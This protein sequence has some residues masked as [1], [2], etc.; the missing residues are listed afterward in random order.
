MKTPKSGA[1]KKTPPKKDSTN[2]STPKATEAK[3]NVKSTAKKATPKSTPKEIAAA[4]DALQAIP[5]SKATSSVKSTE[6]KVVR[7][8]RSPYAGK[9]KS[10]GSLK[11]ESP[12]KQVDI[13]NE[14]TPIMAKVE[15]KEKEEVKEE[16]RIAED[17]K[18]PDIMQDDKKEGQK[19]SSTELEEKEKE[20]VKDEP[21]TIEDVK[22]TENFDSVE[23]EEEILV[24]NPN[25][26]GE[27]CADMENYGQQ[28]RFEEPGDEECA[29]DDMLEPEE[30]EEEAGQMEEEQVQMSD[31]VRERKLKKAQEI[32]VGGLD[33]DAVEDDLK[34]VFETVG[35][36]VEVRLLKNHQT[37]KNKGFAFVKFAN[38]EQAKRALSELKFPIIH[39]KKCGIAS[40]EDNDTLFLGNI[41]NT[42]TKEAVKRKLKEYGVQGIENITLVADTQ[43]EGL[44]RGFAFI[45]FSCHEDG[46]V[47]YKRLQKPDVIFGHAERTAKV[48]FAE[49][50]R[51]PDPEVMAQV[52]SVFIN[53]LPPY[54]DEDHVKEKFE[55]YG[56]IERIVLA[57]NMA[58]AKRKDF[59]FVN[60]ISHEAAISCIEGVNNKGELGDGK[61]KTKAKARLSNP[62]PK[63]QAV[64]GGMRGGF[65]IR[66]FAVGHSG[67]GRGFGWAKHPIGG[68]SFERGR[69]FHPRGRGRAGRFSFAR[70]GRRGHFG[71]VYTEEFI[72]DVPISLRPRPG[73]LDMGPM[74]PFHYRRNPFSPERDFGRPFGGFRDD[75]YVYDGNVRGMK[76]SFSMMDHDSGYVEPGSRLRPCYDFPDPLSHSTHYRDTFGAQGGLYL[77]DYYGPD[78][79]SSA[80]PSFYDGE[81]PIGRRYYY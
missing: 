46:M 13:K 80:Y 73:P 40:S 11:E 66:H 60:F 24:E 68:V 4:S 9:A 51:E 58:S 63:T 5:E 36:V 70:G 23:T 53:G 12:A 7:K 69:G 77:H 19:L 16:P 35:E 56:E 18:K 17:A 25:A 39:G 38:Q 21:I 30:E 74:E 15:D 31:L 22:D 2:E 76:R 75:S 52:K 81:H 20:E 61:T 65:R 41:C 45:E 44:S 32:F 57:R 37:N 71:S 59:G 26:E 48:A 67:F 43:N 3:S 72:P 6:K 28:E 42:W 29:E 8:L 50:L 33:R 34:K 14:Q 78:Y 79:G 62:L 10:D 27:Y 54:W 49:P 64:K 47:A 55:V 1:T